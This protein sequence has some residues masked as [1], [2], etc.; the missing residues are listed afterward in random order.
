M[1]ES[2]LLSG[3]GVKPPG[4]WVARAVTPAARY[5]HRAVAV[6]N[7]AI[8]V[9]GGYTTAAV[10]YFYRYN[11][12]ANNWSTIGA[13]ITGRYGHGLVAIGTKIYC[14]GGYNT[15]TINELWVFDTVAGTWA[16]LTNGDLGRFGHS[17]VAVG[18]KLYYMGGSTNGTAA[19]GNCSVYDTVAKTWTTL[20]SM[21]LPTWYH[22]AFHYNGK[23]YVHGGRAGGTAQSAMRVYDI[24]SNTWSTLTQ[25][26]DP[27]PRMEHT[28]VPL[29][30]KF[31][32]VS[33][34]SAPAVVAANADMWGYD[35][36]ANTWTQI[37]ANT[38]P[39]VKRMDYAAASVDNKMF[40]FDGRIS[41]ATTVQNTYMYS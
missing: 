15:N 32:F 26:T 12:A 1:L 5:Q 3:N 9:H 16:Q 24:A 35:P 7:D 8:Y 31:V 13:T 39:L 10:N 21:N 41:S 25:A 17:A 20:A 19:V 38:A 23:I 37:M 30:D 33:G 6:G 11:I 29:G 14:Y 2:M 27:G 34:A 40:V 22:A 18:D 4:A 28:I 36:V